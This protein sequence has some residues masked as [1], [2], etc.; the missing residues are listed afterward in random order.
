MTKPNTYLSAA[1]RRAERE[2]ARATKR[3]AEV[4]TEQ[5]QA[6][7]SLGAKSAQLRELRLAKE[8]AGQK[9]AGSGSEGFKSGSRKPPMEG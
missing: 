8:A 3:A 2:L 5:E 6:R 7:E 1:R 9:D 4:K